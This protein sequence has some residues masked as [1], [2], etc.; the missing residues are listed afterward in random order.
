MREAPACPSPT[1]AL[2][3]RAV[4]MHVSYH[5]GQVNYVLGDF[6]RAAALLRW[7]V[8]AADRVSSLPAAGARQPLMRNGPLGS[9]TNRVR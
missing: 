1:A 2:G 8:E 6:G 3:E 9:L 7:S 4:Q 5:L